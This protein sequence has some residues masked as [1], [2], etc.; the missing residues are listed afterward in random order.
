ML[1]NGRKPV[2]D[3]LKTVEG[4]TL[5]DITTAAQQIISSPLTMASYGNGKFQIGLSVLD[6]SEN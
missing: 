6:I 5:K 4:V 3:F 2:E 1:Y